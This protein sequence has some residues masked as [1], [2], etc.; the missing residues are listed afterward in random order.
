MRNCGVVTRQKKKG[1]WAKV[2]N[3]VKMARKY[4]DTRMEDI[5]YFSRFVYA[6]SFQNQFPISGDKMFLLFLVQKDLSHGKFYVL[7]IGRKE[8]VSEPFL[9]L[10]FLKRLKFKIINTPKWLVWSGMF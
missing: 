7:L 1:I 9:C 6:Y 2:V 8:K 4:I 10:L 3:C 5:S